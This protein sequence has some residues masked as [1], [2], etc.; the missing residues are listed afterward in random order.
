M[1]YISILAITGIVITALIYRILTDLSGARGLNVRAR[2]NALIPSY[3]S[4]EWE[5]YNNDFA[6]NSRRIRVCLVELG[7]SYKNHNIDMMNPKT[8]KSIPKD[9][10]A[11][12][13]N[14]RL[15]ILRHKDQLIFGYERQVEYLINQPICEQRLLPLKQNENQRLESWQERTLLIDQTVLLPSLGPLGNALYVISLPLLSALMEKGHVLMMIR[16][17]WLSRFARKPLLTPALKFRKLANFIDDPKITGLFEQAKESIERY[18]DDAEN[19]LIEHG[20][21]WLIGETFSQ[22]DIEMMVLLDRLNSLTMLEDLLNARRPQL[23]LYW[24]RLSARHSYN[25]ALTK[26]DGA[27]IKAATAKILA[28]RD[29]N[30]EFDELLKVNH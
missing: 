30:N 1:L 4:Q 11:A 24:Q 28:A 21:D 18:L 3:R 27:S 12:V 19:S 16:S 8:T 6:A 10:L 25:M 14:N 20:E 9:V 2:A 17:F 23:S 26:Y 7:I 22:I 15:P 5:L 29:A 13:P